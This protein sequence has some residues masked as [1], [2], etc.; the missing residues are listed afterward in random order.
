M[1]YIYAYLGL[2]LTAISVLFGIHRSG[3]QSGKQQA[4]ATHNAE[5]LKQIKEVQQRIHDAG[6]LSND[7]VRD[8]LR[9]GDF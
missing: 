2:A 8:S 5:Q 6:H 4:E 9:K 7:D 3:K 1:K